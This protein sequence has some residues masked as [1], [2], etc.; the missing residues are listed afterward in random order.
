MPRESPP[1]QPHFSDL[2]TLL[3]RHRPLQKPFQKY[4]ILYSAFP[5]WADRKDRRFTKIYIFLIFLTP[6]SPVFPVRSRSESTPQPR[7]F[8]EGPL[9]KP[10]IFK[11]CAANIYQFHIWV[12]P[13]HPPD[14][15]QQKRPCGRAVSAPDFGSR[16][17]GF[18]L[19]EA[20]FFPNLNSALLH[21]AFH[22][23]PPIVSKW[24]KYCWRD[25]KP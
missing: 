6:K 16:G 8:S 22:V 2:A 13:H 18:E 7:I 20:R 5:I 25:V 21:R 19:L 4:T 15:R 23:H 14:L 1:T 10:P 17:R 3:F 24:P 12:L 11:Q 9:F